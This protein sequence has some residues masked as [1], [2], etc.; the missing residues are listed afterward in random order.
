[1]KRII[2]L[3]LTALMFL[4]L[5]AGCNTGRT[6]VGTDGVHR[7]GVRGGYH[8]RHDGYANS[9]GISRDRYHHHQT[10][11]HRHHNRRTDGHHYR[12]DGRVTD[13]D[14]IIGNGIDADRPGGRVHNR[15]TTNGMAGTGSARN[16]DR[17]STRWARE[18]VVTPW[19]AGRGTTNSPATVR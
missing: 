4:A 1:M 18:G 12:H 7:D 5:F 11:G 2:W 3:A 9:G 16:T 15:G 17:S 14:G 8:Y 13:T 6:V 10:D 19:S